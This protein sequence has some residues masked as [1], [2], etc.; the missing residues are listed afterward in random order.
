MSCGALLAAL[1]SQ[2]A[3]Q[4]QKPQ[5]NAPLKIVVL[6]GEGA[7]NVIQQKTA[8]APVFEVR[9]RNDQPIAGATVNFV[10]RAGRATFGGARTLTVTTN[11]A[12]RAAAA[13]S[14]HPRNVGPSL[15]PRSSRAVSP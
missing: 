7:V 5:A 6:E 13:G 10:V 1:A 14:T 11:A 9:D 3:A 12:G 8:I 15:A 2:P 4:G